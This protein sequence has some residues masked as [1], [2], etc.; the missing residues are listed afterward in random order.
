MKQTKKISDKEFKA[1]VIRMVTELG[2]I[3]GR[4]NMNFNWELESIKKNH[5]AW[6]TTTTEVE[7]TI[8]EFIADYYYRETH[9]WSG[10]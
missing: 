3:I 9:K 5:S 2:E 6:K 10:R 8:N 7:N 1:L 4:C